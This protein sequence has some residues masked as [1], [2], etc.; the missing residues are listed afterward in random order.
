M[1]DTLKSHYAL[2]LGL[3]SD[4]HVVSVQLA[5]E[6]KLVSIALEFVG[7]SCVSVVFHPLLA[8]I[9]SATDR[10]LAK[11]VE[12][13]K[14]ANKILRSRVP[15]QIHTR[16]HERERLTQR[17]AGPIPTGMES[18]QPAGIMMADIAPGSAILQ[19]TICP[20]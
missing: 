15:G 12:F 17:L 10:E 13:L 9:A 19:Q 7:R 16:N 11:Q 20:H 4:W 6:Q 18:R 1:Q 3:D 5:V 8:L 14:E 2:L